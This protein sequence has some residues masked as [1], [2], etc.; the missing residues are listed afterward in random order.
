MSAPDGGTSSRG[1]GGPGDGTGVT[2]GPDADVVIV[3]GAA[4]GIGLESARLFAA[5]GAA[6]VLVD[7]VDEAGRRAASELG[8]CFLHADVSDARAWD[9]VVA[10]LRAHHGRLD[11]AHLNAGVSQG[12]TDITAVTDAQYR[13]YTGVNIDGVF[14]GARALVPLIE[15]SGGGSIIVTASVGGMTPV[16]R[17]PVYAMTKHAVVGL[18]RSLADD[19]R[20]RGISINAVCPGTVATGMVPLAARASLEASG[21]RLLDPA[22]VARTVL[23]LV[24]AS[25]VH[26]GKPAGGPVEVSTEGVDEGPGGQAGRARE[27]HAGGASEP[28]AGRAPTGQAVLH[29]WG[30]APEPY[31]FSRLGKERT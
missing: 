12:I 8:G 29:L 9:D 16:P 11:V 26:A 23:S 10:H 4:S 5:R 28:H 3:T 14:F 22:D 31:R 13:R 1:M 27:A 2:G 15:G 18:V 6:V 25:P 30:R 21:V 17:D 20:S 24:T 19:L 7:V